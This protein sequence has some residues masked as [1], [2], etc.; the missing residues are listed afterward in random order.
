MS[1]VVAGAKQGRRLLVRDCRLEADFKT[2]SR[3]DGQ[4]FERLRRGPPTPTFQSGHDRLGRV[5][6]LR[7]LFL[8]KTR[9]GARFNE[10]MRQIELR[11]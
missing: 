2:R 9:R 8:R 11:R 7:E 6:A 3:C 1:S 5:H 4:T 10:R